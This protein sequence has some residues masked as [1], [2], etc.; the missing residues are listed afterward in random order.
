MYSSKAALSFLSL[1]TPGRLATILA[2]SV[3]NQSLITR[4]KTHSVRG[5]SI[6]ATHTRTGS[7]DPLQRYG[8]LK[9][10]K[11]PPAVLLDLVQLQIALFD[12]PTP[13]TLSRTKRVLDQKSYGH[14]GHT[15]LWIFEIFQRS[16]KVIDFGANRKCVRYFL[17]VRHSNLGPSLHRFG[18]IAACL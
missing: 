7:G 17:L 3:S 4:V 12:P 16:S 18:D 9:L 11:W 6:A 2:I 14:Y 13:K 15:E 10:P 5:Q 1:H 8:H